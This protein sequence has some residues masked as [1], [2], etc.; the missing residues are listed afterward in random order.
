MNSRR[1]SHNFQTRCRFLFA[2]GGIR[3]HLVTLRQ[4]FTLALERFAAL[5]KKM[6]DT[7]GANGLI[8]RAANRQFGK[9]DRE[10]TGVLSA[11][12]RHTHFL[13]S[14]RMSNILTRSDFRFGD[15]RQCIARAYQE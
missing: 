5:L 10:A 13:N 9:S 15:L 6:Q 8:A 2:Y 11:A 12:Q 3:R 14:A 1:K 4:Y 7:D